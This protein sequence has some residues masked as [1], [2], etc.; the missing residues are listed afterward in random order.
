M[1]QDDFQERT[2]EASPKRLRD[3]REKGQVPRSRD[4]NTLGI[5][6]VGGGSLWFMGPGIVEGI[7]D[8]MRTTLQ[9]HHVTHTTPEMTINVLFN[10]ALHMMKA[11]LPFMTMM[12]L[13]AVVIPMMLGGWNISGKALTFKWDRLDPI[14]GLGRI[15]SIKGLV[16]LLKALAKFSFIGSVGGAW[17]WFAAP[18]YVQLGQVALGGGISL[19]GDMLIEAFLITVLPMAAIAAIDVPFQLWDHAKQLRMTRK[20]VKDE[21]KETEGNPELKARIRRQ[22]QELAQQRMMQAVPD[23]DVVIV[24]PEHYAVALKYDAAA[25]GAPKMVAKG[26][27][28][29]AQHIREVATANGV[30]L[31]RAPLLA[32]AIYYN[33]KLDREI[34]SALY[35]AVAQVLAYVYR[36]QPSRRVPGTPIELDDVPVPTHLRTE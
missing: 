8:V 2:E 15:F 33:T 5:L 29:V 4:L 11:L 3:A 27:D 6:L 9:P 1:A 7:S 31:V 28:L 18:S 25:A 36:V 30:P 24:N 14:K 19:G 32:R 22:Q 17:L 35:M 16:E 20:E 10:A 34:P 12:L 13:A 23:A 26:V 21:H